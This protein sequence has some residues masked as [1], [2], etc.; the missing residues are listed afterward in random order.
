M[1]TKLLLL[2]LLMLVS[3]ASA[4]IGE[5]EQQIE[6]GYGK[7]IRDAGAFVVGSSARFYRHSGFFILVS[8]VDGKSVFEGLNKEDESE[9]TKD[10]IAVLLR[11][12]GKNWQVARAVATG[13]PSWTSTDGS[14]VAVYDSRG[15]KLVLCSNRFLQMRDAFNQVAASSKLKDF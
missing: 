5:T 2:L 11:A 9:I 15:H 8:F 13:E 10:E 7:P 14:V 4:R 12:N 3:P 1:K 6:A